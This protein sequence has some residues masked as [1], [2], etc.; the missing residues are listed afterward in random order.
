MSS[1]IG[2]RR[3]QYPKWTGY[4]VRLKPLQDKAVPAVLSLPSRKQQS[5]KNIF[6]Y[7]QSN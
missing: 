1:L 7:Q 2:T 3:T 6:N 5:Q 4:W